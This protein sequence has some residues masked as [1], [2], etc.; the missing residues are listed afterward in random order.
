MTLLLSLIVFLVSLIVTLLFVPFIS[1][2][3]RVAGFVGRDIHKK[4]KPEVAELGGL[5][6]AAGV[7]A[8]ILFAI[9]ANSF[10]ALKSVLDGGANIV[11]LLAIL[12]VVLIIELI[13]FADDVLGVRHRIKFILPVFAALPL[14][15]VKAMAPTALVIPF[16]GPIDFITPTIYIL[17]LIPIGIT[18]S[19]NLTNVFAGY[20]GIEA[21]MGAVAAAALLALCWATGSAEGMVL[22][23]ALLG[24]LLAFLR[25]NWY[26]AKVF[27]DDV[28]TLLIGAMIG[29]IVI[30]AGVEV[31]GV[32]LLLPHIIDF[33][34]FKIPNRL[35]STG[36]WGTLRGGKLYCDKSP[37]Q[38]GQFVMRATGGIT[39]K[40]LVHLF[41]G[42]EVVLA[43]IVLLIY[44]VI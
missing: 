14:M 27:P 34:F 2:A 6:I 28:G 39:E 23:A 24:A 4:G 18:A 29:A 36:W 9:A 3:A 25:F 8:A 40:G 7:V 38:F 30:V 41:V 22:S 10:V 19:T 20:N 11:Y 37:V 17:I 13:G 16:L 5:A 15:A 43:L 44:H 42:I 21:G 32:I 31:A 26:P 35:P 12:C 1:A 33:L